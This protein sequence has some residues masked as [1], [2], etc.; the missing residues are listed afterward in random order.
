MLKHIK[1]IIPKKLFTTLQPTYHLGLAYTG[2]LFY[3]FPS[4]QIRVVAQDRARRVTPIQSWV[5]FKNE[6]FWHEH[7]WQIILTKIPP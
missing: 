4:K 7:A 2:A 3:R 5:G 6:S 1:K